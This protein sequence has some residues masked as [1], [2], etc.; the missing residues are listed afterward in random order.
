M[1][2]SRRGIHTTIINA[3]SQ[4]GQ[5][6]VING[7]LINATG[8]NIELNRMSIKNDR[9]VQAGLNT[10]VDNTEYILSPN[11]PVNGLDISFPTSAVILSVASTSTSD[12]AAGTGA[13]S[14][15]I[16][17]LDGNYNSLSEVVSLTGQ[18]PSNTTNTF[19]RINDMLVQ[20]AG[21]T[22]SNEGHIY[23]SDSADTFTLGEP[24]T[25]LYEAMSIG[26]N[27]SKTLVYTVPNGFTFAPQNIEIE[28]T[29]TG[30]DTVELKL[31]RN[32]ILGANKNILYLVDRFYVNG[33]STAWILEER[34]GYPSKTDVKITAFKSTGGGTS[35][36]N[37]RLYGILRRQ[38]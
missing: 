37:V 4:L 16:I 11:A 17:G 22:E 21:S 20:S 29:T 31:F 6:N 13:R 8:L 9:E 23:I 27:L 5:L 32:I 18:V 19:L 14:V 1:S 28:S 7:D 26:D 33:G 38:Y 25:R 30:I 10:L 35:E 24:N 15:L 12:T 2:R 34:S 36:V 3:P